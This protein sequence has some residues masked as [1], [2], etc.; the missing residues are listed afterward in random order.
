MMVY[1]IL[2]V[3]VLLHWAHAQPMLKPFADARFIPRDVI[4]G[5]K[6]VLLV[7]IPA[8][9]AGYLTEPNA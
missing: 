6:R 1:M 4:A 2:I 9:D 8:Q 7:Q 3:L 5:L